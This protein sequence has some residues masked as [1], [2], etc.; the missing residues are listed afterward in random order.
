MA[1]CPSRDELVAFAIGGLEPHEEKRVGEHARGCARCTRELEALA[2]A[3]AM[4]GESVAQLEPPAELRQRVMAVVHE[5][6]ASP[7]AAAS[8]RARKRRGG[9]SGFL[10][11]PAV[12]L[13]AVAVIAAGGAGYLIAGGGGDDGGATTVPVTASKG[14]GGSLEVGE[15]SS[16]LRLHDMKQ[17][18]GSEVYQVWVAQGSEVRPS[19]SFLPDSDGTATATVDGHLGPGTQVMVTREPAAGRTSPTLP[20]LMNATVD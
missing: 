10:L 4:L 16:T 5:E 17:L 9:L 13:A 20:S 12:G 18:T 3:V 15:T 7:G 8:A 11:R 6:A 14:V 19:S 2:P 1:A